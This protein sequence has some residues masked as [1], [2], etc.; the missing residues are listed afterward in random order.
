MLFG[1]FLIVLAFGLIAF[2]EVPGILQR[3]QRRDLL[4]FSILLLTGLVLSMLY[5][6]G[7]V[8]PNPIDWIHW[9]ADV[10]GKPLGIVHH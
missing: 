1:Q 9:I 8:L 2:Y 5:Q 10:L 6:A 3:G 7:V 4:A